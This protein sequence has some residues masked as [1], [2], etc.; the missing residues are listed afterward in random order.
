MVCKELG[1][2]LNIEIR[3]LGEITRGIEE[4]T[5][6]CLSELRGEGKDSEVTE[7]S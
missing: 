3:A 6:I 7:G 4:V 2:D 1:S 5:G